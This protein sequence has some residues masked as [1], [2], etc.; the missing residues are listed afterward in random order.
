MENP[1]L[2]KTL[3]KLAENFGEFSEQ[4]AV[5]FVHISQK[6]PQKWYTPKQIFL[7]MLRVGA[8][9]LQGAPEVQAILAIAHGAIDVL[10]FPGTLHLV[11]E[12]RRKHASNQGK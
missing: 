8:V 1:E 2:E 12:L 4:F 10:G 9:G 11:L 6:G 7:R 3:L 5:A